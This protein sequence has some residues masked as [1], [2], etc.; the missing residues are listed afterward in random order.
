MKNSII[1]LLLFQFSYLS[2]QDLDWSFETDTASTTTNATFTSEQD[3]W[4]S[5]SSESNNHLAKISSSG[6][7]IWEKNVCNT[8]QG[9]LMI[10]AELTNSNLIHLFNNGS[11][12]ET[13]SEGNNPTLID[14]LVSTTSNNINVRKA[15]IGDNEIL[16]LG[17]E[18]NG[19]Y[20][21]ITFDLET[22][23]IT[24]EAFSFDGNLWNFDINKENGSVAELY[25]KNDSYGILVSDVQGNLITNKI[26]T[27]DE[28]SYWSDVAYINEDDIIAVGYRNQ[29]NSGRIGIISSIKSNGTTNWEKEYASEIN[30]SNLVLATIDQL[31][32]YILVGGGI[33][34][35]GYLAS[36]KSSGSVIWETADYDQSFRTDFENL[37]LDSEG[38]IIAAG[39]SGISDVASQWRAIVV[40]YKNL[41][42][43][44]TQVFEEELFWYPNPAKHMITLNASSELNHKSEIYNLSGILVY[45]SKKSN[46]I[47]VSHLPKGIYIIVTEIDGTLYR[48]KLMVN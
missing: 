30:D 47:S 20:H 38:N 33:G 29:N 11:I 19:S 21:R 18:G 5:R 25:Q 26:L 34:S 42:T 10:S 45:S 40:K 4:F 14:E 9:W 31:N 48:N 7:L 1:L 28:N 3:L 23:N 44:L 22:K 35:K 27:T 12:Y 24:S 8:C 15:L 16:I 39:T 17:F 32:E 13:D 41:P 46:T 43:S 37:H 6:D 2:S 36:I